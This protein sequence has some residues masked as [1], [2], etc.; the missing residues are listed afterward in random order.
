MVGAEK[1]KNK[2]HNSLVHNIHLRLKYSNTAVN[3][4]NKT[5]T[6]FERQRWSSLVITHQK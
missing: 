1:P 4:S 3:H 6:V 2:V 5:V